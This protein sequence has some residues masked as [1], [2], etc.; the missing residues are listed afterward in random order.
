MNTLSIQ[1]LKASFE[2]RGLALTTD[3]QGL[4]FFAHIMKSIVENGPGVWLYGDNSAFT[5]NI[6]TELDSVERL[7]HQFIQNYPAQVIFYKK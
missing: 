3:L 4:Q 6:L 1:C 2:E 7:L 5:Q